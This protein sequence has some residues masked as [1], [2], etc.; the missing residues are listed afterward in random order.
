MRKICSFV[1]AWCLMMTI[2]FFCGEAMAA[3]PL[4][5][6]EENTPVTLRVMLNQ[7]QLDSPEVAHY[8][9][10]AEAY[11][12]DHPGITFIWELYD[13]ATYPQRLQ[14][15][16]AQ[17][18]M[19][20]IFLLFS[21]SSQLL[22]YLEGGFAA[23]LPQEAFA[24]YGF[25]P[26][27][28]GDFMKDGK[29]YALPVRMDYRFIMYNEA[30]FARYGL[31]IPDSMD[32]LERAVRV[33]RENGIVPMVA[34]GTYPTR[35]LE[36]YADLCMQSIDGDMRAIE[37]ILQQKRR[38]SDTPGFGL[39]TDTMRRL[40][41]LGLY[42]DSWIKDGYLS[43]LTIFMEE[44]AAMTYTGGWE[45]S[46]IDLEYLPLSFREGL[47]CVPFPAFGEPGTS[48]ITTGST[49]PGL[50]IAATTAHYDLALDVLKEWMRPER[51]AKGWWEA[52]L[53]APAQE[54]SAYVTS[55]EMPLLLDFYK[56]ATGDNPLSGSLFPWRLTPAFE[57]DARKTF[58]EFL[59]GTI[60]G[61]ELLRLF[62]VSV[63]EHSE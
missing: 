39:A 9:Q 40:M 34:A 37:D 25:L 46:M 1:T 53:G 22:P 63:V 26:S 3:H 13:A 55:E 58:Y 21:S 15:Y 42:Q 50:A 43:A 31:E 7:I 52:H 49:G 48:K 16:A 44:N 61:A 41:D 4:G 57:E 59:L 29:L 27:A 30:L 12:N 54:F 47:R 19:P 32:R 28:L 20:D 6:S 11:T 45:L 17:N 36:L 24:G 23:E 60:D 2:A 14:V 62:D 51:H 35:Q 38:F 56:I 33:F 18:N 8:R 5:M 10:C